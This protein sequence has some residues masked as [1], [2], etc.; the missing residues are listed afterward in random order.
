[1][2]EYYIDE[3]PI[4]RQGALIVVKTKDRNAFF[5]MCDDCESQWES[6]EEAIRGAE[7][8]SDEVGVVDATLEEIEKQGW[9]GY[10]KNL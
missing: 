4:C 3:C 2:S 7:P 8:L 5:V 9:I 6:P 1:M 10:I